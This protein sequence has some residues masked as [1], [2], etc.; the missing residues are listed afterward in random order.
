MSEKVF[1]IYHNPK[2][3]KSR[4]ALSLLHD[5]GIEPKIINYIENPL[6]LAELQR[7]HSRLKVDANQLIRKQEAL[8]REQYASDIVLSTD[9]CLGL[10]ETHPNL[11]QRPI[12]V[13]DDRAIIARP[14]EKVLELIPD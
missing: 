2:C 5:N 14:P 9:E 8:Y 1:T 6:N 4:Q 11:L 3:S 7:L 10:L 12:I 13:V